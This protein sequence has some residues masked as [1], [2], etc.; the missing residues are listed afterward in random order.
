MKYSEKMRTHQSRLR[1]TGLVFGNGIPAKVEF[2]SH[3]TWSESVT[4]GEEEE[5]LM[6]DFHFQGLVGVAL[7]NFS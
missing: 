4:S 6:A 5:R 7:G 1:E 2:F 3:N